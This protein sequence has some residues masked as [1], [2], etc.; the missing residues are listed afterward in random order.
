[1]EFYKSAFSSLKIS[2]KISFKN[3]E[4][5]LRANSLKNVI[6]IKPA[7][8]FSLGLVISGSLRSEIITFWRSST[9]LY[10]GFLLGFST[11]FRALF[12]FLFAIIVVIFSW[13]SLFIS[14]ECSAPGGAR[15]A[16]GGA[17]AFFPPQRHIFLYCMA[18]THGTLFPKAPHLSSGRF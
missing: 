13:F 7:F 10:T 5:E 17:T 15:S 6:K 16:P 4:F 9:E 12:H 3:R 14:T 8:V 18:I 2:V 1:M 11:I